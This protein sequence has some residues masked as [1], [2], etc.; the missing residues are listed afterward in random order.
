MNKK[1]VR[2]QFVRFAGADALDRFMDALHN[3][4][5]CRTR[6]LYWQEKLWEDFRA[7]QR[8]DALAHDRILDLFTYCHR[9]DRDLEAGIPEEI[10]AYHAAMSEKG[11]YF[12]REAFRRV[13]ARSFPFAVHRETGSD[14]SRPD[15]SSHCAA[16]CD[17]LLRFMNKAHQ[18]RMTLADY[19]KYVCDL[20]E[21]ILEIYDRLG[22]E[23]EVGR[24]EGLGL[25]FLERR[26][27]AAA[28]DPVLA[29]LASNLDETGRRLLSAADLLLDEAPLRSLRAFVEG[30][31]ARSEGAPIDA[32]RNLEELAALFDLEAGAE[33]DRPI[34]KNCQWLYIVL[35]EFHKETG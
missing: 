11:S 12:L 9:H 14:R 2:N 4:P 6:L 3:K 31:R 27:T 18:A 16:C 26:V 28:S 34:L 20:E 23:S 15:R 21:E 10:G 33:A 32:A 25:Y 22:D 13:E 30:E 8:I 17:A 19:D 29:G 1:T 24:L 7:R 5:A 35:C